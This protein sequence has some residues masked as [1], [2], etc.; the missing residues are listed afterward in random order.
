[1]EL[2]RIDENTFLIHIEKQDLQ[3][4]GVSLMDLFTNPRGIEDFFQSII[5]EL[6]I[7]DQ[8]DGSDAVTFQV[9][10]HQDGLELYV[11]KSYRDEQTNQLNPFTSDSMRKVMEKIQ[12]TMSEMTTEHAAN[13]QPV[14]DTVPVVSKLDEVLLFADIEDFFDLVKHFPYTTDYAVLYEFEGRYV[15]HVETE[16][17]PQIDYSV[18][19]ALLMEYGEK[20]PLTGAV[21]AEYGKVIFPNNAFVAVREY[22]K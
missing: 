7:E 2:E 13:K 17:N 11:T 21:L 9:M 4:R 3:V 12:K 14:Q 22:F 8:F 20:V 19:R 10:P 5:E 16:E 18:D 6:D 1:M 15:L